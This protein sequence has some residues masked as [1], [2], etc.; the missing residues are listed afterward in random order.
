MLALSLGVAWLLLAP[1]SLWL[2]VR[3]T[4]GERA[5]AIVTL[6]LLEGGTIA[7]NAVLQ[8]SAPA[9]PP[10]AAHALPPAPTSCDARAPVPESAKVGREVVLSWTAAPRECG[11]ADVVVRAKD[12]KLLVWLYE[13]PAGQ[14]RATTLTLSDRKSYT[15]PVRIH[16][17]VAALVI[18]LHGKAGY[19]PID[20][21]SGR[22]IPKS[23]NSASPA[24]R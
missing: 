21:R 5:G 14:G 17:G 19:V 2:L 8:P 3:G 4:N 12:R 6:A 23:V 9:P 7:M 18:P 11:T 10:A 20:G 15:L 24:A 22:Q 1:L 13:S 16:D